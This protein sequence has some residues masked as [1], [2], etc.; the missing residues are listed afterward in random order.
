MS[1]CDQVQLFNDPIEVVVDCDRID[2]LSCC[3]QGPPGR[4]GI[5]GAAG[6]SDYLHTQGG[7]SD[8]WTVAHNLNRRPLVAVTSVGGVGWLGG[9]I[10]HL[11]SNVL[12]IQF[13]EPVAGFAR[14]I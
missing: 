3:E 14:C 4:D 2:L 6:F 10:L 8:N 5:D 12:Q 13:D 1:D 11:S 9:E 7:T